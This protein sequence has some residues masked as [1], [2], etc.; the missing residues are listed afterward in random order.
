METFEVSPEGIT[1]LSPKLE[2]F[3]SESSETESEINEFPGIED[4][5]ETDGPCGK[6]DEPTAT[7]PAFSSGKESGKFPEKT[8]PACNEGGVSRERRRSTALSF[9][10]KLF[11]L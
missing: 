10:S 7:L 6:T 9:F 3:P 2:I 1:A 5:G 4:S 11:I 8:L